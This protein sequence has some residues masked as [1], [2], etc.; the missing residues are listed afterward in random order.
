MPRRIHQIQLIHLTIARGIVQTHSLRLYRNSAFAFNIHRIQNLFF[1]FARLQ[2]T[3]IFNQPIGQ[4]RFSM[5]YMRDDCK[6]SDIL[7]FHTFTPDAAMIHQYMVICNHKFLIKQSNQSDTQTG[8]DDCSDGQRPKI[9]FN[10][11]IG[12][13]L[14]EI[15]QSRNCCEPPSSENRGHPQENPHR[16]SNKS[17][18]KRQ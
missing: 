14:K 16:I 8:R 7:L 12:A 6:I 4:S 10:D 1:H 9:F 11:C 2:P 18:P 5:I 17:Q 13:F 15:Q 3:S